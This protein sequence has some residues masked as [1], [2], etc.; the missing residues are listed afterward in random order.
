M[1]SQEIKQRMRALGAD[2]CGVAPLERLGGAPEGFHPTD[3]LPTC[4]SVIAFACRFP[5]GTLACRSDIPYTIVRNILSDRLDKMAV[6]LCAD[7]EVEGVLAVP[8]GTIGPT[9]YD[10]RTDR[11]RNI[12]SAKHCAEAAGLGV[13]GL[14]TLLIT[15]EFGNM[16]W[17][18][19]ILTEAELE[20]DEPLKI[21]YCADCDLCVKACPVQ[22]VGVPEL[23]QTVCSG[24]CFNHQGKGEWR[25]VCH[26]CRDACPHCFGAK[27]IAMKRPPL[28]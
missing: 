23:K 2:L 9:E 17:L 5:A 7:L 1:T 15:P 22:A 11:W 19:A 21:D 16:V 25:I 18:G 3:V 14:N 8:T 20:P 4:R 26:K 6:Q 24:Y 27:N 12:V 13:I 10:E 28:E